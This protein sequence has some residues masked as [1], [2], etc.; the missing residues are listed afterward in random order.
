MNPS[1]REWDRADNA[2]FVTDKM[3]S[4]FFSQTA[5][6]FEYK[7]KLGLPGISRKEVVT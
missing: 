3:P 2:A 7:I 6:L 1:H 5:G 4:G